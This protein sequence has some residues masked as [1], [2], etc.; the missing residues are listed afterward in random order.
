MELSIAQITELSIMTNQ[1]I[2]PTPGIP[3]EELERL[4]SKYLAYRE[5]RKQYIKSLRK[6]LIKL[7][8]RD[9]TD[10][11]LGRFK[12]LG[13]SVRALRSIEEIRKSPFISKNSIAYKILEYIAREG[14]SFGISK[15]LDISSFGFSS[16]IRKLQR[17]GLVVGLGSGVYEV[18]ERGLEIL[19]K[20]S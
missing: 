2:E 14:T 15:E 11:E 12:S 10:E 19:G 9:L 6:D 18:T 17:F 1:P 16:S 5:K 13:D 20:E 3:Q 7:D 4:L 8:P